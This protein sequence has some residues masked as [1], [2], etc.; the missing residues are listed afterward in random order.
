M[1]QVVVLLGSNI[2][3]ERNL[4]AAVRL[5]RRLCRVVALSPVYETVPMGLRAQPNF[6]NVAVL[7][8]TQLDPLKFKNQVLST[9]E[10][11]LH[12]VRTNDKNAPRTIDADIVLFNDAVM[13]WANSRR[14]PDP[15]LQ[16]FPHVAVPVA[17]LL[18]DRTHPESGELLPELAAR[19]L[20]ELTAQNKDRPVMWPRPD[21]DQTLNNSPDMQ[22]KIL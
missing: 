2:N 12:R 17:D 10:T 21:M 3:K 7:V 15:D 11:R 4:P 16:K 20:A 18:P 1:N 19:L 8:E 9:I 13:A 22:D 5:L 6:F 14:L